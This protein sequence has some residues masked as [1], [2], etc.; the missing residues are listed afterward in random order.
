MYL[1]QKNKK[2]QNKEVDKSF[3]SYLSQFEEEITL[4]DTIQKKSRSS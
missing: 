3:D 1:F 4:H 2:L